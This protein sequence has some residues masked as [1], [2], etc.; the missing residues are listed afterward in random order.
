MSNKGLFFTSI[1]IASMASRVVAGKVSDKLGRVPV[2]K[3]G[4]FLI[5]CSLLLFAFAA[6]PFMLLFAAACLG[7]SSGILA[8]AAFAWTVDRAKEEEKGKA[9][10]TAYIFLEIGIGSGAIIS[11]WLYANQSE[12]FFKTYATAGLICFGAFVFL[13]IFTRRTPAAE[14]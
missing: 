4:S 14:G 5:A 2:L 3:V 1:T 12:L 13:Q 8:P 6:T 10:A 11:A 9:L 7:F